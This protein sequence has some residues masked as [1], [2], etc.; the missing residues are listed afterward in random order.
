MKYFNLFFFT[1]TLT[2][3]GGFFAP[4]PGG[5]AEPAGPQGCR[6]IDVHCKCTNPTKDFVVENQK[7]GRTNP[8]E[9]GECKSKPDVDAQAG[10]MPIAYCLGSESVKDVRKGESQCTATWSCQEPCAL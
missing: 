6:V 4:A 9:P 1:L 10:K 7:L 3:A 8:G 2:L 5:S